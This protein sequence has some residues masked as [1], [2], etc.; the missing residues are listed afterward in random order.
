[1]QTPFDSFALS[2]DSIP[3]E[4]KQAAQPAP[5]HDIDAPHVDGPARPGFTLLDDADGRFGIDRETGIITLLHDHLLASEAGAT[6]GVHMRCIEPSGASYELRFQLRMTGLIP[7]IVG[8]EEFDALANLVQPAPALKPMR[9]IAL[10]PAPEPETEAAPSQIEAPQI[11]L[12]S[13]WPHLARGDEAAPF[14]VLCA[15]PYPAVETGSS[16]LSLGVAPPRPGAAGADWA[17]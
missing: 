16:D 10:A 12:P 6:H 15:A 17:I 14:G 8:A 11:E 9:A 1:M 7:Q 3:V 2:F 5:A 13:T 4:P